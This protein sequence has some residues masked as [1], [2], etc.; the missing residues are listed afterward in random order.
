[1]SN[2]KGKAGSGSFRRTRNP[3]AELDP[4]SDSS[5]DSRSARRR[6]S[7]LLQRPLVFVTTCLLQRF[8]SAMSFCT[9]FFWTILFFAFL[10]PAMAQAPSAPGKPL[11]PGPMQVKVKASC[12]TCHNANRIT[13]QHLSRQQW[14]AELEKMES[15]GAVIPDSDRDAMLKYLTKNFGL[16]KGVAGNGA[17]KSGSTPN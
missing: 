7:I 10:M 11:P 17:K 12:T 2:V 3:H 8:L 13:E 15:L 14:S 5:Y 6:L 9:I 16:E 1:M 4:H